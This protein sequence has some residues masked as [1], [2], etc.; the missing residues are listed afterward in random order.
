MNSS[1]SSS[2]GSCSIGLPSVLPGSVAVDANNSVTS[3]TLTGTVSG[4]CPYVLIWL[5]NIG[6]PSTLVWSNIDGPNGS[7]GLT[8]VTNNTWS[9][10]LTFSSAVSSQVPC[11]PLPGYSFVIDCVLDEQFAPNKFPVLC[12]LTS[13]SLTLLTIPCPT[14]SNPCKFSID[15][16]IVGSLENG[17]PLTLTGQSP[18]CTQ[19]TYTLSTN[20][21][22]P[23][24]IYR[25]NTINAGAGGN[26]TD[27]IENGSPGFVSPYNSIPCG[28]PYLIY[29]SCTD[30]VHDCSWQGLETI[31]VS[32]VAIVLVDQLLIGLV[33]HLRIV[34]IEQILV[35]VE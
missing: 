29:F 10:I 12:E 22:P 23:Q 18:T 14:P 28:L 1:S 30:G 17:L 31:P 8:P 4:E 35:V 15:D 32:G 11:G 2:A 3:L 33:E 6:P 27:T 26:W 9:Q 34:L 20:T 5:W 16:P 25:S 21:S 13:N 19:F 7:V 24:A